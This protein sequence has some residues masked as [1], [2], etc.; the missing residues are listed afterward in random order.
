MIITIHI[1]II[2]FFFMST[3][4]FN[5]FK[6]H[7]KI[8]II[9]WCSLQTHIYIYTIQLTII[10]LLNSDS[11]KTFL[12]HDHVYTHKKKKRCLHPEVEISIW[13]RW[14]LKYYPVQSSRTKST[15]SKL[16]IELRGLHYV[17]LF[18]SPSQ[19]KITHLL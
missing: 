1:I 14:S 5:I 7:I 12:F 18:R 16:K 3:R 17:V 13:I 4:M 11:V 2:F 9:Y 15:P 19:M 10:I 8:N 6:F